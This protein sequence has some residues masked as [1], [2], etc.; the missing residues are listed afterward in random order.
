MTLTLDSNTVHDDAIFRV[1]RNRLFEI[2][3][4]FGKKSGASAA[5]LQAVCYTSNKIRES[6]TRGQS[7][8]RDDQRYR[9]DSNDQCVLDD[10]GAVFLLQESMKHDNLLLTEWASRLNGRLAGTN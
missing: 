8:K 9:Y 6:I 5:C 2:P 7:L 10:L 4:F 3:L 1:M